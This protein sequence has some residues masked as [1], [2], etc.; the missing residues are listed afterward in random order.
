MFLWKPYPRFAAS[1]LLGG[2]LTSVVQADCY[3]P[4]GEVNLEHSP[5]FGD[6]G[7]D[8]LCCRTHDYCLENHVCQSSNPLDPGYYRGSCFVPDF[9]VGTSC[10]NFCLTGEGVN[11]TGEEKMFKCL[12]RDD[13]W[14]CE[15]PFG[16]TADCDTGTNIISLSGK[17]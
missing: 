12:S 5:C 8:G 7:Y 1:F 15:D 4:D 13:W 3:W 10:P 17:F 6:S 16:D 2:A 9:S 11:L 14:F